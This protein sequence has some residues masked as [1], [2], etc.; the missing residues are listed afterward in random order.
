VQTKLAILVFM[1][2]YFFFLAA[3]FLAFFLAATRI[4]S[5]PV[6]DKIQSKFFG[7]KFHLIGFRC[8]STK[9]C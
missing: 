4:T 8:F 1:K 6:W 5:L 2:G 9:S 7:L 3:F